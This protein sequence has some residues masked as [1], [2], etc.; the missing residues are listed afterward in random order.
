MIK[1]LTL[2]LTISIF[3]CLVAC[4]TAIAAPPIKAEDGI[5]VMDKARSIQNSRG[6]D[7]A[8]AYLNS[9]LARNPKD[10]RAIAAYGLLKNEQG[11]FGECREYLTKALSLH[12]A[13]QPQQMLQQLYIVRA[14]AN[15][16]LKHNSE[17]LSDIENA[18]ILNDKN[19][20]VYHIRG[21]VKF[22]AGDYKGA[23]PDFQRGM[24]VDA[25]DCM[26]GLAACYEKVGQLQK[27][28][29]WHDKLCSENSTFENLSERRRFC[30]EQGDQIQ[31]AEDARRCV[32]LRP[33]DKQM[34]YALIAS[35]YSLDKGAE[36]GVAV[37][38][39]LE[40]FPQDENL[41]RWKLRIDVAL[42]KNKESL[43]AV[44]KLLKKHPSEPELIELHAMI[45]RNLNRYEEAIAEFQKASRYREPDSRVLISRAQCYELS[46]QYSLA[47]ED[48]AKLYQLTL[49]REFISEAGQCWLSRGDYKRA[50]NTFAIALDPKSPGEPLKGRFLRD[51]YSGQAHAYL[52]L[53]QYEQA[54][55][56]ATK[57]LAID[58]LHTVAHA[59][60]A[61]A[62]GNLG[63]VDDAIADWSQ[64]IKRRR[65]F[66]YAYAERAK[67]YDLKK[68]PELA[69]RD[70]D[71]MR[72]LS[73]GLE[74]DM[75][76]A[77][78]M[79]RN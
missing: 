78:D 5:A 35:L 13:G 68:L 23:I 73:K 74:T 58:P 24:K 32:E 40:R 29:F 50:V 69:Q 53:K 20:E 28:R 79:L 38:D 72:T 21:R 46:E 8:Y 26:R 11:K 37:L 9:L 63:K 51:L 3:A 17:A 47:A 16:V 34:R 36:A 39:A 61:A 6:F 44:K 22:F 75:F 31:A 18:R 19:V 52:R 45:L 77:S 15:A 4:E 62:N 55:E 64:A 59:V 14:F 71:K 48:L 27:A 54:R 67:L 49:S 65:D 30:F 76:P 41:I 2:A 42:K 70:R 12:K 43:A 56:C 57:A 25:H 33:D 60:R 7:A 1:P 66:T 10:G